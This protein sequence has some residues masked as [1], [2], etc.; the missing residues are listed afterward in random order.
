MKFNDLIEMA[1]RNLSTRKLRTFLTV[2]GVI[3]GTTS[4]IVML[5]LGFG[6]TMA[7]KNQ[8]ES[9]GDL[10]VIDVR[11][12]YN[13]RNSSQKKLNA[14][15][16]KDIKGLQNVKAASPIIRANGNLV[17]GRFKAEY[18]T[19]IGIDSSS[20]KDFGYEIEEGRYLRPK[21]EGVLFG[22]EV[23]RMFSDPKRMSTG[24]SYSSANGEE[25][26]KV[27]VMRNKITLNFES[28]GMEGTQDSE[29]SKFSV[30]LKPYGILKKKQGWEDNNSIYLPMEYL[31]K[32]QKAHQDKLPA[33]SRN[34]N[35]GKEY[36]TIK[37]KA[38][39]I[40]NVA[41]LQSSIKELGYE[42]SS[43]TDWLKEMQKS[44]AIFQ[45]IFGG[46]GAISLIVASIGITNTMIMSIYERTREIGVMKVIGA[47]VKDIERLFLVEA[48][49]IGFIG[50][51]VGIIL[52]YILSFLLNVLL[53]NF[54]MGNPEMGNSKI[55][56]IPLWLIF[57]ALFFSIIIGVASG[58]LPAK[59]AVKLSALEAIRSE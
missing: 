14:K 38:N 52:S 36:D 46:I 26:P 57:A 16:I 40:D 37:V 10:T 34:K 21:D 24:F 50:G 17:S 22:N 32:L 42:A 9:M 54:M 28:P 20:M 15:S 51:F 13:T 1:I 35:I 11:P 45:A 31:I 27:D 5:S 55:S 12:G 4:I 43:L 44:M 33:E 3:I 56:I 49:F 30:L 8:I 23:G 39:H 48:A 29:N 6:V 18:L 53:G 7:S 19:I 25:K 59:R 47:S 41:S 2:L 58:F